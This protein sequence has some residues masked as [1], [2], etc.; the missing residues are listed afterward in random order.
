MADWGIAL[1]SWGNPF[2]PGLKPFANLEQG[3]EAI[4]AATAAKPKTRRERDYI[5]AASRLYEGFDSSTQQSRLDAYC[6]SMATVA[7]CYPA[8]SEASVFYALSLAMSADLADKTY[9][10]QRKAGAILEGLFRKE[11]H[12][13][14]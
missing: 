1:T 8:D 6:E 2:A 3:R 11:P 13:P 5:A 14:G 12:H 7:A 4:A 9:A 10:R